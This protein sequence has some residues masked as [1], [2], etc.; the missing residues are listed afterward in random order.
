MG[1]LFTTLIYQPFF[2]LLVSFYWLLGIVKPGEKPDMGIAVILLTIVI[3][4][5]LLPL[6]MAG[7]RSQKDRRKIASKIK[8][9]EEELSHDPIAFQKEKKKII[10]KGR[11]VL[12]AEI[13][14]LFIQVSISLM[15]WRIFAT[16]LNGKDLHLLYSFMPDVETPYNLVFLGKF[17]LT[18]PNLF[19]NFIQS[20]SIFVLETIALLTAPY[21]VSRAEVVRLQLILPVISFII[22]MGL[23]AGKKL[24]IITTLLFSIILQIYKFIQRKFQAYKDKWEAES[25]QTDSEEEKLVLAKYNLVKKVK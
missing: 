3:R 1:N 19:L 21:W 4:V 22:F 6:S 15:L 16:G 8:K 23:P 14:T 12:I 7:N 13:F 5:L 17:D 24:F 20:I 10:N 11:G 2:N 18:R 9:L 25:E